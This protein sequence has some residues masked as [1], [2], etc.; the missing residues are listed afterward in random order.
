MTLA[1]APS[2][3]LSTSKGSVSAKGCQHISHLVY[4]TTITWNWIATK[5]VVSKY[6]RYQAH[7]LTTWQRSS[8]PAGT[9]E[10]P[11]QA[12]NQNLIIIQLL[13]GA[14]NLNTKTTCSISVAERH[15][16]NVKQY[17][18]KLDI[19]GSAARTKHES[20]TFSSISTEEVPWRIKERLHKVKRWTQQPHFVTLILAAHRKVGTSMPGLGTATGNRAQRSRAGWRQKW[21]P[22]KAAASSAETKHLA[23]DNDVEEACVC[24]LSR[25][26]TDPS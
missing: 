4:L 7:S 20:L 1:K 19:C 18:R 21:E 11:A 16:Q 23:G 24:L 5:P 9:E 17:E 3:S 12:P 6:Y 25:T 8:K 22:L 14:E 26:A 15:K 13:E 2:A 10:M